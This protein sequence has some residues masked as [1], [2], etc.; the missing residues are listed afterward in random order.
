ME[1][2]IVEYYARRAREYEAIYHKPERQADLSQL[3]EAVKE[4]FRDRHVLEIA[5]GTGFWTQYIAQTARSVLAT[6]INEEVLAIARQKDYPRDNA[7]FLQADIYAPGPLETPED[8]PQPFE[9]CF[10]GFIWSHIPLGEIGAFLTA[11]HRRVGQGGTV[12]FMD[13]RYVLGSSTPIAE[14]DKEGN[15]YQSRKLRDG[16]THK[17]IK[18]FPTREQL[19]E[20]IQSSSKNPCYTQ[21]DYFWTLSYQTL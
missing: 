20:L 15:T 13:N 1:N 7:S 12:M 11:V 6:D 17:V 14:R 18:N 16:S 9:I 2:D 8:H 19:L 21:Y 4:Q 3:I 5:C 10:G